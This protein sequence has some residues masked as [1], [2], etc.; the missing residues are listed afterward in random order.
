MRIGRLTTNKI[1]WSNYNL[2]PALLFW[3]LIFSLLTLCG[4]KKNFTTISSAS[5]ASE[6]E[7]M[8][9]AAKPNV[10]I[11][12]G[13]D[14][15]YEVPTVDG[16]QSYSTP[17]IDRMAKAGIRFTECHASP[18]CSPARFMLLTGKYNFRN[19]TIWGHMDLSEKTL[20]NMFKDAGY[21]TCYAGKWQL[22]GGDNSIRNFG[23][24]K[25]AVYLPFLLDNEFEEGSRYKGCKIYQDGGYLPESETA[26][27]YSDDE[28]TD[29]LINFID[30]SVNSRSPFFAYYSLSLCHA[31]CSPTPDDPEYATWNFDSVGNGDKKFFPSMVKYMDKKIGEILA[32]L[33][34]IGALKNTLVVYTG[35]NGTPRMIAS[36][37]NGFK[38][39][40]GK[41]STNEPGTNVPLIALWPK[42]IPRGMVNNDLISFVDFLPTL[43][44]AA[45]IP[46]PVNYGTL[47]GVSFY[48]ALISG[49]NPTARTTIYNAFSSDITLRPFNRWT[50]NTSYKL[51]DV[52]KK[53]ATSGTFV[54]I[55]QGKVDG[56]AISDADLTPAEKQLK[57]SFQEV[58]DF[59]RGQ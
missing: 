42:R 14:V 41:H 45:G 28:F 32:H 46:E 49:S 33:S 2:Q 6:S 27:K 29:Y 56:P 52:E 48:P 30:S 54:K 25:Y 36:Q 8:V 31:P 10:L 43:A 1:T 21:A 34:A 40:G 57:Q 38:V 9:A 24:D 22:D 59:Y 11:I 19:Y 7:E 20:G 4:C 55:E 26:D 39:V 13:D 58:L 47:D 17:N 23:F 53:Y 5:V 50:Q 37:F 3:G 44:D 51:Y 15:G 12:L 16:G 18:L 35:D